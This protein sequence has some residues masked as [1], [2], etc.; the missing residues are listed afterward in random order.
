MIFHL[1]TFSLR[2]TKTTR[3]RKEV[4]DLSNEE[5]ADYKQAIRAMQE[6][7]TYEKFAR[8]HVKHAELTHGV[9]GF[10]LWHRIFMLKFEDALRNHTNNPMATVP[11]YAAFEDSEMY[12]PSSIDKSPIFSKHYFGTD[13]TQE[14]CVIAENSTIFVSAHTNIP[15]SHCVKRI[16]D[17]SIKIGNG[18]SIKQLIKGTQGNF[19]LFANLFETG[20]HDEVH[21][22][23]G[24]DMEEF[25][26]VND[27]ILYSHHSF[28]DYVYTQ[29][30][31]TYNHYD[32]SKIPGSLI[33]AEYYSEYLL[34]DAHENK[35]DCAK[36]VPFSDGRGIK[37]ENPEDPIGKDEWNMF[38]TAVANGQ[39]AEYLNNLLHPPL[40]TRI[41]IIFGSVAVAIILTFI[42]CA[43]LIYRSKKNK[44][45][46]LQ[47][48][49]DSLSSNQ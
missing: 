4:R 43:V 47:I 21:K 5:W 10:L 26:S 16:F 24:G 1:L 29:F 17:K 13:R 23:I 45:E 34:G 38:K 37:D 49:Q 35:I 25:W 48:P 3:I 33:P 18:E 28:V 12:G 46:Y 41:Q 8:I 30:Q 42:I 44:V 27:P 19:R 31:E 22:F 7:G 40:F 32:P 20:Y 2:C 36:Y 15:N 6:D 14:D 11:Y 9:Y 39:G